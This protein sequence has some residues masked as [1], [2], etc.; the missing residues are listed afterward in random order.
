MAK[1]SA[2]T[3]GRPVVPPSINTKPVHRMI[4]GWKWVA[5]TTSTQ[6]ILKDTDLIGV[7]AI[8]NASYTSA[9]AN[10]YPLFSSIR[11][12]KVELWGMSGER[13]NLTPSTLTAFGN[14]FALAPEVAESSFGSQAVCSY[15]KWKPKKGSLLDMW[16]T[17][18]GNQQLF[19]IGMDSSEGNSFAEGCLRV[20]VE[21]VLND[22]SAQTI[23][24]TSSANTL[25]GGGIY[26]RCLKDQVGTIVYPENAQMVSNYLP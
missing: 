16:I 21:V 12:R 25:T 14:L 18:S 2:V 1:R 9:S 13:L 15:V 7:A 23:F 6:I 26:W 20:H 17:A 11:L 24:S 19:N 4:F 22:L 10:M 8:A 5:S 3:P